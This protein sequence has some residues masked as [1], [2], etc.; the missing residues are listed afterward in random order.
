MKLRLDQLPAGLQSQRE[1]LTQCLEAMNRALPVREVYLFGSHARGDARPDS[2]VDLCIVADGAERQM[3][4]AR[5]WRQA[6]RPVWPRPA[7]TL[8]PI[9][10][11]R[12]AEKKANKD[13][14]FQ[15]VLEEGVLLVSEN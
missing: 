12:L 3:E 4:A 2:D 5:R 10:P 1:T 8:L 14:F 9:S 11:E 15:T 13:H 6:M 7:F